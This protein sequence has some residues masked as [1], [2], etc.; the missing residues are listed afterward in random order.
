MQTLIRRDAYL[1]KDDELPPASQLAVWDLV[2]YSFADVNRLYD[3]WVTSIGGTR[4]TAVEA[5]CAL[6]VDSVESTANCDL[7]VDNVE[8]S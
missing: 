8:G 4:L 1:A 3:E 5:M 2:P 6:P 7:G